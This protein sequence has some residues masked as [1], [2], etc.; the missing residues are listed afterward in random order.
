MQVS[1]L[2]LTSLPPAV[3]AAIARCADAGGAGGARA[4]GAAGDGTAL[5]VNLLAK[6]RWSTAER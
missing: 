2:D 3:A 4:G 5:I 1:E 6:V